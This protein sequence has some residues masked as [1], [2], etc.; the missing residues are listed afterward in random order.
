MTSKIEQ[1]QN[2]TGRRDRS[3]G[4]SARH[5]NDN[6]RSRHVGKPARR[7]RPVLACRW[8]V[9]TSGRLECAWS[10]QSVAI[11]PEE[12]GISRRIAVLKRCPHSEAWPCHAIVATDLATKAA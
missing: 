8:Q 4:R 9:T 2:F 12:P 7:T 1:L 5:A 10:A 6:H 3:T 11:A